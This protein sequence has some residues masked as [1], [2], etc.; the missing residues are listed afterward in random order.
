MAKE[1]VGICNA[2]AILPLHVK[3]GQITEKQGYCHD[4]ILWAKT[5]DTCRKAARALTEAGVNFDY[6]D[7]RADG[8]PADVMGT[9]YNRVGLVL[10]NKS[11]T[12]WRG[13][14]DAEKT[15]D[16]LPLL[17]D[18]PTLMKRPLITDGD[19]TTVGWREDAQKLWL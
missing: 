16:M 10:V 2:Q 13:F 12:P 15:G 17:L 19:K 8:V 7:V 4:Q 3:V 9:V 1:P 6:I 11:S 5:C 18:H 14:S